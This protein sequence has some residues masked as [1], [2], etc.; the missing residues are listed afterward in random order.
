MMLTSR[1]LLS[2]SLK[3]NGDTYP[4]Y[5]LIDK[6]KQKSIKFD[7]CK[8]CLQKPVAEKVALM[9]MMRGKYDPAD[10]LGTWIGPRHFVVALDRDEYEYLLGLTYGS[11]TGK[12]SKK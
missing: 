4:N 3:P 11:D 8:H 5:T 2:I 1:W 9:R 12:Q 7:T 10:M 6:R